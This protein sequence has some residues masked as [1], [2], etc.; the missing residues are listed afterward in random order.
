MTDDLQAL[1][2]THAAQL[3]KLLP[4]HLWP[5]QPFKIEQFGAL[6][7]YTLGPAYPAP[8]GRGD[9]WAMLHHLTAPDAGPPHDHPVTFESHILAGGYRETVYRPGHPTHPFENVD[10]RPGSCHNI[11]ADT[12]HRITDLPAGDCWSLCFASPVVREWRHYPELV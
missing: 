2:D 12:I 11:N 4:P 10:R 3:Q 7:K 1:L 5:V 6:T 8:G 9:V